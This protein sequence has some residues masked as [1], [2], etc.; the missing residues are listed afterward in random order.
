MFLNSKV[1]EQGFRI[2]K[3]TTIEFHL[4]FLMRHFFVCCMTCVR[5]DARQ[6]SVDVSFVKIKRCKKEEKKK[7]EMT[8]NSK[9]SMK[10]AEKRRHI[11]SYRVNKYYLFCFVFI[12]FFSADQLQ[13]S[14]STR[15][16]TRIYVGDIFNKYSS[17]GSWQQNRWKFTCLLSIIIFSFRNTS[18]GF[19]SFLTVVRE[20][21][22]K[23]E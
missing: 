16:K 7:G 8:R 13:I 19:G 14:F 11:L 5:V 4:Y 3:E 23:I 10:R 18:K 15:Y 20:R 6:V 2:S 1:W 9:I 17:Y 22:C 12:P 21:S